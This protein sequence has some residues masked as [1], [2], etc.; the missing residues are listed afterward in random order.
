MFFIEDIFKN[1]FEF[2]DIFKVFQLMYNIY[3]T[4]DFN[5][6][7][8]DHLYDLANFCFDHNCEGE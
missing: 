3:F 4:W 1:D 8:E 2:L 5:C 7:I 6:D